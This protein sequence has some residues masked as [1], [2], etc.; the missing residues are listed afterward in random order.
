[1]DGK[2]PCHKRPKR[3]VCRGAGYRDR[4]S[5]TRQ[6]THHDEDVVEF[7]VKRPWLHLVI[8]RDRVKGMRR[9]REGMAMHVG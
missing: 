8:D 4:D 1:M 9:L 7:T 5:E 2:H 6:S 3:R